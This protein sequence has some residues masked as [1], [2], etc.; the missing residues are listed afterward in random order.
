VERTLDERPG[1]N[2]PAKAGV[3]AASPPTTTL[4]YLNPA[5]RNIFYDD[6]REKR[7]SLALRQPAT[8]RPTE[9]TS[10]EG[11]KKGPRGGTHKDSLGGVDGGRDLGKRG[12]TSDAWTRKWGNVVVLIL[13]DSNAA[14]ARKGKDSCRMVR[15]CWEGNSKKGGYVIVYPNGHESFEGGKSGTVFCL[16][17]YPKKKSKNLGG[18]P[19]T[20]VQGSVKTRPKGR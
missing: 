18:Y 19:S 9:K 8:R 10:R 17:L 1:P 14:R 20:S 7:K 4:G 16:E 5:G 13:G 2:L 11:K 15:G 6:T 3:S 12:D